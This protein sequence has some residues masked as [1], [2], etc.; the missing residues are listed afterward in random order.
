MDAAGPGILYSLAM[1]LIVITVL[2]F[3]HEMGHYLVA[4]LFKI[5]V[6]TFSIGF[7]REI[8]GWN[9]KHGTRWKVSL[10]PLGGYVKFFGDA[11]AASG[12]D[13]AVAGMSEAERAVAFPAKPVYQRAAV[14]AAGPVINYLFA[15][16]IFAGFFLVLG[17]NHVPPVVGQVEPGSAAAEAGLAPGDR[18]IALNGR[19]V[20][21]YADIFHYVVVRPEEKVVIDLER[22][23]RPMRLTATLRRIVER[24]S[25]G[26]EAE[27]GQLGI[28]AGGEMTYRPVSPLEALSLGAARTW[29][30]Q[31]T[32]IEGLKRIILGRMSMDQL[33]GPLKIAKYSGEAASTGVFNL[34]FMVA[35][36]S[37]SLG[38]MNLL[39]I[40]VLD[41]GHLAFY[42]VEAVR[43]HPLSARAQEYA[44]L[45]GLM[46]VLVFFVFV[47][48]NDLKSFGL[49]DS[50]S[51]FLS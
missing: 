41:G 29:D 26:N 40:P 32:M 23:G 42:A 16:L 35:F 22:A 43:G 33:G 18:I 12:P 24:D 19:V 11:N 7:G 13:A 17:Y 38:F 8:F 39:P 49:W 50:L 47:T 28:G 44:M 4:R 36:I 45:A 27:R 15:I 30:A 25:F 1:F 14:V 37:I 48:W 3:V 6:E 9:D 5:R 10:V 21:E 46:L 34:I 31:V 2:V 20:D 51:N